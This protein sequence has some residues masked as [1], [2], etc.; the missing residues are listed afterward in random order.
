MAFGQYMERNEVLDD[1]IRGAIY[2][3]I[4]ANP[5]VH[6]NGIKKSLDLNTGALQH[7]LS[8]LEKFGFVEPYKDGIHKCYVPCGEPAVHVKNGKEKRMDEIA[9]AIEKTPGISASKLAKKMGICS[10][11]ISVYIKELKEK[12][13]IK[14]VRNGR[15]INYLPE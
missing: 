8:V 5:G 7:H 9:L 6:Y 1:F 15:S 12:G 3:F 11:H 13:S 2:G 10:T 14:S 4:V